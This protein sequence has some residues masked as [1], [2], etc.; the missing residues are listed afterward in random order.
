MDFTFATK[1]FSGT[2]TTC[3]RETNLKQIHQVVCQG[4]NKETFK[5]IEINKFERNEIKTKDP[6]IQ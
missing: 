4:E 5:R 2:N 1:L 3:D 6:A